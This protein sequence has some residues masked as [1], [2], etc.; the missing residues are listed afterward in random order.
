MYMYVV[1]LGVQIHSQ[2]IC[3][4][5]VYKYILYIALYLHMY[6]LVN[7]YNI[8]KTNKIYLVSQLNTRLL[9]GTQPHPLSRCS[10]ASV[11]G[12]ISDCLAA[13]PRRPPGS[14]EK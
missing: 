5:T 7:I 13:E 9:V 2:C 14:S 6:L 3:I 10:G 8:L 4:E 1:V 11:A 12:A